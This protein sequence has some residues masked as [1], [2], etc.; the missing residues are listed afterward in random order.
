MQFKVLF[1]LTLALSLGEREND[2]PVGGKADTVGE[3]PAAISRLLDH[4]I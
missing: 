3:R 2:R 4:F 1:P